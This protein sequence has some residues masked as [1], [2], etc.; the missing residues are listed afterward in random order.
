VHDVDIRHTHNPTTQQSTV[1]TQFATASVY[2]ATD[3][4]AL[5]SVEES[6]PSSP[7]LAHPQHEH[8]HEHRRQ[9]GS[10]VRAAVR[11]ARHQATSS[12]PRPAGGS[13]QRTPATSSH[14]S[15]TDVGGDSRNVVNNNSGSVEDAGAS[16][17]G[18]VRSRSLYDGYPSTAAAALAA[19]ETGYVVDTSLL[20]TRQADAPAGSHGGVD[21]VV[22]AT[23]GAGTPS[24][25]VEHECPVCLDA[26]SIEDSAMR[27]A[28]DGGMEHYFHA[29]CLSTWT[30]TQQSQLE[31]PTC[32][33]CRGYVAAELRSISLQQISD[34]CA[35]ACCASACTS[36]VNTAASRR[37]AHCI[38]LPSTMQCDV[39]MCEQPGSDVTVSRQL[40]SHTCH[41]TRLSTP[42]MVFSFA[43]LLN[44]RRIRVH[45][46]R[47][48]AFLSSPAAGEAL[49]DESKTFLGR[50]IAAASGGTY[51]RVRS[52]PAA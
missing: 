49:D 44:F 28:G 22:D 33:I 30:K 32:P 7:P 27:C 12:R 51:G 39:A 40:R 46:E 14:L 21:S 6:V 8:E 16:S 31:H 29:R 43:T 34:A 2:R 37:A 5:T 13:L 36:A 41:F 45:R 48:S 52:S 47:L 26:I 24:A 42:H 23:A 1:N 38:A 50:L 15:G 3:A 17:G 11:A 10:S 20:Q 9:G 18:A 35:Q 4:A 19:K 25:E